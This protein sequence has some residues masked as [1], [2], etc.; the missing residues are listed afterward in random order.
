MDPGVYQI[1]ETADSA[2]GRLAVLAVYDRGIERRR[3]LCGWLTVAC[4]PALL[5]FLVNDSLDDWTRVVGLAAALALG[6]F[7]F[8]R[9]R[10]Y[11]R[12]DLDNRKIATLQ[13]L[14]RVLRA[15]IRRDERVALA[16]DLRPYTAVPPVLKQGAVSRYRHRWLVLAVRLADDN[17][18]RLS[19][20]DRV[21]RKR[22]R[23]GTAERGTSA[24]AL[25]VRLA[26]RY[27]P[28]EPIAAALRAGRP[29]VGLVAS[30]RQ[31]TDGAAPRPAA[32]R[33]GRPGKGGAPPSAAPPSIAAA[34][35]II[36]LGLRTS[37][38]AGGPALA[39]ADGDMLLHVLRWTY[40]AIA[41]ARRA[42]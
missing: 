8:V 20:S 9:W 12:R 19:V 17:A 33:A 40:A 29:P 34:G 37:N 31:V 2:L 6:S 13:R 36:R 11:R 3:R 16:V 21:K 15:D 7:L 30:Q 28:I 38:A 18:L 24:I 14:L 4:V 26:K 10:V 22:K 27:R 41:A 35:P 32:G 5:F 23:K 25:T 1:S 39:L 42:A